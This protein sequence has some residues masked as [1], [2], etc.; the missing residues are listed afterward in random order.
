MP[1]GSLAY[2]VLG[3]D[4]SDTWEQKFEKYVNPRDKD[5]NELEDMVKKMDEKDRIDISKIPFLTSK[6][7][8]NDPNKPK[9]DQDEQEDVYEKL[10]KF[11]YGEQRYGIFGYISITVIVICIVI[12][13]LYIFV[14]QNEIVMVLLI[15]FGA[16]SIASLAPLILNYRSNSKIYPDI[17]ELFEEELKKDD[18][19]GICKV[20]MLLT[21]HRRIV[22]NIRSS[23]ELHDFTEIMKKYPGGQKEDHANLLNSILK[24]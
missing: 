8:N 6:R 16:A 17:L 19:Y 23:H 9:M 1:L 2:D 4:S 21:L 18:P 3:L 5:Y 12:L 15:I 20:I 14:S 11:A 24:K 13:M 7:P 10:T 22:R